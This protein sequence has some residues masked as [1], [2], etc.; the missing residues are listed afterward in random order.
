MNIFNNKFYYIL[1][2]P[3]S[4]IFKS[5]VRIR[6]QFYDKNI[7][8]SFKVN[9]C[10]I[11]S[12][13][14]ISVGGTGKT[15]VIRFLADYLKERG[16]N[17]AILSRGY[18]RKSK[19]TII[20]SDGKKLLANAD[21]AGDEPF[22][23]ARQLNSVPIVAEAD[24]YKGA[25]LIQ[26]KFQPE[27]I[28]LD[29]AFQH[30][31][32]RRDFDIV[33]VDA[34]VGFGRGLLLPAGFLREPISSLERADLIWVTRID[35][36]TDSR[37]LI[38]KVS[39]HSAAPIITSKHRTVKIVQMDSGEQ[40]DLYHLN[41]KRVLLFSGIGNPDSFEKSVT[42][43]GAKIVYHFTFSDHYHYK[44]EDI[45]KIFSKAEQINVDIILT[46][47]KDYVRIIELKADLSKIY[48]LA[49]EIHIVEN[50]NLLKTAL[51]SLFSFGFEQ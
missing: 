12:I 33:L 21:Q 35:Q 40:F 4:L 44:S 1:L 10:K 11:I 6:N 20:V 47:E 18:N 41:R 26:D 51:S 2:Y 38:Q 27:V 36:A 16:F 49:I 13:G 22:L 15:P 39:C 14:N 32:L 5:I 31:R 34:S 29:D 3:F 30:R 23:L 24:R 28:L 17:V 9:G 50:E 42:K 19:G 45:E 25:K 8:R 46:T 48:Y 43:L 37:I 7:F